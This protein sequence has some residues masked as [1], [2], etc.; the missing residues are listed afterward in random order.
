M[1]AYR[2]FLINIKKTGTGFSGK[3]RARWTKSLQLFFSRKLRNQNCF[4]EPR[5][6][7]VKV[8]LGSPV[9]K[10]L[11]K[12]CFQECKLSLFAFCNHR[13]SMFFH[14]VS[15]NFATTTKFS[16][17]YGFSY[18]PEKYQI[19]INL[20]LHFEFCAM[21]VLPR[22]HTKAL[23][24]SCTSKRLLV[25]IDHRVSLFYKVWCLGFDNKTLK[26]K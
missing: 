19:T 13:D 17:V 16:F 2:V 25:K 12:N 3:G 22:L 20:I 24:P 5:R 21:H 8:S 18:N 11:Y 15:G 14:K 6:A 9:K 7:S 26:K 4:S 10:L 1:S 23:F